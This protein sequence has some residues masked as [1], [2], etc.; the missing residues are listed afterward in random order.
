VKLAY[1]AFFGGGGG[2]DG[3]AVA[4]ENW[5]VC[6][7]VREEET[8][9]PRIA[10]REEATLPY[11]IGTVDSLRPLNR[12]PLHPYSKMQ[13]VQWEEFLRACLQRC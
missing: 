2:G 5:H 1:A 9:G 8:Y 4:L 3:D 10:V 11:S 12:R 6:L 7:Q 13:E